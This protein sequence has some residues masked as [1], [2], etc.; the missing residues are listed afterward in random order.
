MATRDD[1]NG[2][3]ISD[4]LF[5]DPTNGDLGFYELSATFRGEF[6]GWHDIASSSTEYSAVGAGDF[7]GDRVVDVLMRDQAS[8]DIGFYEMGDG[9]TWQGWHHITYSSTAYSV[10]GTG[11]F[12]GDGVSDILPRNSNNGDLGFYQL[13][14]DG[15]LQGWHDIGASST[16]YSVVGT[17]DLNNDGVS[18]VLFR[19]S[20]NGDL[21]FYQLNSDGCL[22]SWHDIGVASTAYAVVGTGDFNGDVSE[23][24]SCIE[25]VQPALRCSAQVANAPAWIEWSNFLPKST[26]VPYHWK[27]GGCACLTL[28]RGG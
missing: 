10:V 27:C 18:D 4:V 6:Q 16:D 14:S 21:G 7:N 8:G 3:R 25:R 15:S 5:R 9:G 22:N 13:N 11:D 26:P 23:L 1:F 17:D 28:S 20:S 2:D 19:N 12:N 24:N